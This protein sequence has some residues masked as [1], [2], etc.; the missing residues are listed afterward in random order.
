M[1]QFVARIKGM[2]AK[3]F[4]LVVLCLL[5][6]IFICNANSFRVLNQNK[7]ARKSFAVDQMETTGFEVTGNILTYVAD[8]GEEASI[9]IKDIG[10]CVGTIYLDL[11][12]PNENYL[13]YTIYYTDEANQYLYRNFSGEYVPEVERT[14]WR[15]CYFSGESDEIKIVFDIEDD[16]YQMAV[17]GLEVNRPVA[18]HFSFL[19]FISLLCIV[20]GIYLIRQHQYW[21]GPMVRKSQRLLLCLLTMGFL[22]V[23]WSIYV[24]SIEKE[25]I[26]SETGDMYS[27]GLTDALI[28]GRTYLDVELSGK[29]E[30][31]NN[32]YDETERNIKGLIRDEDYIMDAAYYKGNY[33]LY[34][35]VI[36]ALLFFVP[37]KLLTGMYLSTEFVVFLFLA[38]YLVFLNLICIKN[39]KKLFPS[40][41]FGIYVLSILIIDAGSMAL[42]FVCR[43]KFYEMVY[44]TG[45]AFS[46]IGLFLLTSYWWDQ[47]WKMLKLF[48]GGL[49]LALAVGC[50][51]TMVFY[52]FLLIPCIIVKLKEKGIKKN[53]KS[54]LVLAFPY[55][56]VAAGLMWYN[57][58]RFDNVFD[59][60]QNYQL[61]VT[62]M[63]KDSYKL[64]TFPWCLWFGMFQ[65]L[66]FS[67]VFP[68]VTSGSVANDYAG[69]FYNVGN[70]IPMFSGVPLLYFMFFPS[71]WKTW[72][73]EKGAF[74]SMMLATIIGTGIMLSIFIFVSAGVHIRYTA[75][76]L[77]LLMIG[78]ILLF[79]GYW[80]GTNDKTRTTLVT[81]LFVIAIYVFLVGFLVGIMGERDWIFSRHPEFY[82]AVERLFCFW[83]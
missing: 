49:F 50:R 82:F 67:A 43:A 81:L 48:L 37:F 72:K 35:G 42:S 52:S 17:D 21:T 78:S 14:K 65:P 80:N 71:A 9:T 54:F 41:S 75:E 76:P 12:L 56:C 59:F 68:F 6:E 57:Y 29:L 55:V 19:R 31:L 5:V 45:L 27:Q 22:C 30:Q 3:I 63:A 1:K 7:Y 24:N 20:V 32:P 4:L 40:L 74:G 64:S 13:G 39:L 79:C 25:Q 46:S 28:S 38:I 47:K 26:A 69:Y 61:T 70:A 53:L 66:S 51:P 44:A 10:T 83:K 23:L 8:Y 33:Y 11:Y 73:Q 16:L 36:P 15:T 18:F 62:D 58:V 34:F 77:P 60:G 2:K